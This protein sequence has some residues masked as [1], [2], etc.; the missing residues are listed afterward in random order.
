MPIEV[1]QVGTRFCVFADGRDT[2]RWASTRAK[3]D[4]IASR[5]KPARTS[6]PAKASPTP[7]PARVDARLTP[8]FKRWFGQSKVT[9]FQKVASDPPDYA[10]LAQKVYHGT[11]EDFDTFTYAKYGKGRG[12]RAGR[13]GKGFYFTPSHTLAREHA[14]VRHHKLGLEGAPAEKVLDV[15]LK[16]ERPLWVNTFEELPE[17]PGE[18]MSVGDAIELQRYVRQLGHDGIIK[19]PNHHRDFTEEDWE[20]YNPDSDDRDYGDDE[21]EYIVFEPTQVKSASKNRGTFDP[22]DPN[23][24]HNPL[25]NKRTR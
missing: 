20:Y 3:A 25:R 22:N 21:I 16:M 23:I 14:R 6:T 7:A 12:A 10:E 17:Y 1:K 13:A 4:E 18:E 11:I 24:Y 15:Y 9:S 8:E 2:G 19:W 5:L